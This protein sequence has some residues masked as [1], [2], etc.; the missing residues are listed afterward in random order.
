[1]ATRIR[2]VTVA[3]VR[4][5]NHDVGA[6]AWDEPRGLGRFE[7]DPAFVRRGL[8]VA[9][10][11]MP[12]GS[13]IFDFPALN[14]ETFHGLPGLLADSLPD[15]YGNR[16]I[17]V[18]LERQGRAPGDFTPVER[19]CYMSTRGMGALEFKPALGP[20][21]G[22]SIP[23]EVAELTQLAA[24]ILRHR[25]DWAVHLKGAKAE[26]LNAIIRVGTSAGGNRAKAVVAWNPQTQEVRS[27]QA[28]APSGF[29]P[30]ILKF[31]GVNDVT[32]G[33]P[34]GFGRIEYAYHR[35]A[36]AAG[37]EMTDCRLLEESGRA[38]FMTRRFDRDTHGEKIHM[39]SLCAVGHYDFNAA[40]EY[41]Y[42]Q[43]FSAIQRLNLGH[44]VMREMYRR[45]VFNVAARNQDDHTRNIAFLMDQSGQWRLSPAFD[46]IWSYNPSGSWTNRH[47]MSINGKRDGF[48]RADL[49]TVAENFGIKDG[50]DLI[51]QVTTAV[52][53]WPRFAKQAG[54]N[55]D[56]QR[57]ISKTH[58]LALAEKQAKQ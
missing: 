20:A 11:M 38:H 23:I 52:A 42:E 37:I 7:Y 54:V 1:M 57:T 22:K 50:A 47:Q 46:V 32:L 12:L 55:S 17:D 56:Q 9:P 21:T 8:P 25:T 10:L 48:T 28:P 41:G 19:L 24:E 33:D 34:K 18:W 30:W 35:M 44:E 2:K 16:L 51:E 40:G 45:M 3:T 31:D 13:G 27:G 49:L 4:L 36:V 14:R 58:R 5:W 29:E 53:D 43:A 39:Q 26:A 6:V 15:R